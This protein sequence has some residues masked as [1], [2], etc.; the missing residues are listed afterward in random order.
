MGTPLAR[1]SFPLHNE[2]IKL[3]LYQILTLGK[4]E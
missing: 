1:Q 4:A 3:E 2:K